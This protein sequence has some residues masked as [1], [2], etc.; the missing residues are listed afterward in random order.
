M[1]KSLR[2]LPAKSVLSVIQSQNAYCSSNSDE[3][4]NKLLRTRSAQKQMYGSVIETNRKGNV[5]TGANSIEDT[6]NVEQLDI[7]N[8]KK[9]EMKVAAR[10]RASEFYWLFQRGS[11]TAK[12]IKVLRFNRAPA[13]NDA[14]T[15]NPTVASP[16]TNTSPNS[17]NWNGNNRST[18]ND[19]YSLGQQTS[20]TTVISAKNAIISAKNLIHELMAS[21][22]VTSQKPIGQEIPFDSA[23]LNSILSYPLIGDK[24]TLVQTED[25]LADRSLRLPS[26][27]KVLQATMPESSRI[28]LRK[29]KLGKIAE[30]GLDGFKQYEKETLNRGKEFHSAIEH[31]LSQG[32]I[33]QPDSSIIK[34]WD[35]IDNSLQEMQPKPILLEQPIL[36]ADLKY[37]GIIDN[38]SVVR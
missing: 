2:N 34:L 20:Q 9:V 7:S 22:K 29:W 26:I 5:S 31:F 10:D 35:S 30:L 8:D 19:H 12:N 36:H 38:V 37:K 14:P 3:R 16:P 17:T 1:L 32:T 25:L 27:S 28:A 11:E 23:A 15:K 4:V 18:S 13:E 21:K 6:P 24:G 33:P